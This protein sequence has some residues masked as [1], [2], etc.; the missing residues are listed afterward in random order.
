MSLALYIC[1]AG[2][3]LGIERVEFEVE[4][5][6]GRLAGVD[7]TAKDL[8][9]GW[10]HRCTFLGESG[11]F[12]AMPARSGRIGNASMVLTFDVLRTIDGGEVC[13]RM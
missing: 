1:L 7:R 13:S 3:A 8:A 10:L 4:I 12:T 9:F 6:F 2:L 5:M 11:D